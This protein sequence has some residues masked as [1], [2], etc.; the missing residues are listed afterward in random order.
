MQDNLAVDRTKGWEHK[1]NSLSCVPQK[2][3][4]Y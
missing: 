3:Q 2:P 4:E 1:D